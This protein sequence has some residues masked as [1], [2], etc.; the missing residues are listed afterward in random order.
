MHKK[1]HQHHNDFIKGEEISV[2]ANKI[3]GTTF[4]FGSCTLKTQKAIKRIT[5]IL[6]CS[7]NFCTN[8]HTQF[9]LT[10]G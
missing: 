8:I 7:S 5:I 9:H 1:N 2:K 10:Q 4:P 6:F 3:P